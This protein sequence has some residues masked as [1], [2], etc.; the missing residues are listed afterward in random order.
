MPYNGNTNNGGFTMIFK[1]TAEDTGRNGV[2]RRD[3]GKWAF[4][5][6][7]TRVFYFRKTR[8]ECEELR[9]ILTA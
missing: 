8:Q 6:F 3:V 1:V 5:D 2:T 4:M 9:R 7:R